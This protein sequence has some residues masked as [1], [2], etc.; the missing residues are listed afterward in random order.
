VPVKASTSLL[1]VANKLHLIPK[2]LSAFLLKKVEFFKKSKS[3][4]SLL[5]I[6]KPIYD[7]FGAGGSR[8]ALVAINYSDNADDLG[9]FARTVQRVG[10]QGYASLKYGGKQFADIVLQ[11]GAESGK[12]ALAYEKME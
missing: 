2:K 7:A 8:A 9:K 11:Y 10:K 4:Q 12:K 3:V 5:P 6:M 1:K